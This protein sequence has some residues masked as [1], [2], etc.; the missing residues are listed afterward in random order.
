MKLARNSFG[1]PYECKKDWPD[2]CGVQCGSNGI[3][4]F[5]KGN[6]RTAFFEAFP[7]NPSTFIRGEGS[8]IEEAEESA[9]QQYERYNHCEKH[10]F[11]RRGYT[12]G[13]GFCKHC[14]LFQ[15]KIFKPLTTCQICGKPTNYT[16][17]KENNFYCREHKDDIPEELL[18]DYRI[19]MNEFKKYKK[20]ISEKI[21]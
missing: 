5:K 14:G 13:S 9:W 15:S 17:D 18:D 7:K 4:L 2:N 11:E 20:M 16:C 12:N 21:V 10:E 19:L 8:T 1:N 3:V 6:Y